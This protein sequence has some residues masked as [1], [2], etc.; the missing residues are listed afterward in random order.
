MLVRREKLDAEP[1]IRAAERADLNWLLV[2][3]GKVIAVA[4]E[5]L[6]QCYPAAFWIKIDRLR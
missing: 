1:L 3:D 2:L 6:P 5:P 4:Y